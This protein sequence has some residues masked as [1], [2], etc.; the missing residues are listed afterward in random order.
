MN[1]VLWIVQVLLA[2]LFLFFGT[3]L[4]LGPMGPLVH[5]PLLPPMFYRFVGVLNVLGALGLVLPGY[6]WI[7]PSVTRLAA[8]GLMITPLAAVGLMITMIGATIMK[9]REGSAARAPFPI[10][11]GLLLA[12]V[13]YGR[14]RE[15]K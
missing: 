2:L 11:V 7:R 9:I 1:Y 8:V 15:R 6:V 5:E 14:W 4:I 10:I 13:A 3:V 12:F